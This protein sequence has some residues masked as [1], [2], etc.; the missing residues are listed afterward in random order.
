MLVGN[1]YEG[2]SR[3]DL[4][5]EPG[6]IRMSLSETCPRRQAYTILGYE[7]TNPPDG[8]ALAVMKG[9]W[10]HEKMM[11][12]ELT[13]LGYN[14]WNFGDQQATVYTRVPIGKRTVVFRGHCDGFIEVLN[15]NGSEIQG[16][17][18]KAFRSEV[19][20]KYIQKAVEIK[21]G[22]Y[23]LED[24]SIFAERPFPLIGQIQLYLHSGF[25][26][27]NNVEKWR[28]FI[29]TKD[30]EEVVEAIVEKDYS[31]VERLGRKWLSF[32]D[33]IETRRLPVRHFAD[34]SQ[35]CLRCPFRS[36]CWGILS[37]LS[38]KKG[39]RVI[40]TDLL[41]RAAEMKREGTALEKRGKQMQEEARRLYIN[42]MEENKVNSIECDGLLA[43]LNSRTRKGLDQDKV[44][45]L[46][47]EV[48]REY[49]DFTKVTK[50]T[51][52][53]WTDRR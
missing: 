18:F 21:R 30:T 43:V 17:E 13:R 51:E 29:K 2:F 19:T 42:A 14:I 8:L 26:E 20:Q 47:R 27:V 22:R 39:G 9:G 10:T 5:M 46:I 37:T 52:V 35:E 31:V 45:D 6:I 41:K 40:E 16:V 25:S 4:G 12:D 23:F 32:W 28:V 7:E 38:E 1:F 44:K 50:Y 11:I 15:E 24:T 48:G 3:G 33:L 53:R 34:N 49:D 36:K